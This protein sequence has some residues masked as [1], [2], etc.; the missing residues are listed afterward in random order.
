M[1]EASKWRRLHTCIT[2]IFGLLYNI[3]LLY[4]V[5]FELS[6]CGLGEMVCCIQKIPYNRVPLYFY[7]QKFPTT[8]TNHD[9]YDGPIYWFAHALLTGV[10]ISW[11]V[12]WPAQ[13]V[14][15][16]LHRALCITRSVFHCIL[17]YD[18]RGGQWRCGQREGFWGSWRHAVRWREALWGDLLVR[19]WGGREHWRRVR[20]WTG[21]PLLLAC[22]LRMRV[23]LCHSNKICT[24]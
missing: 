18:H 1:S 8:V 11:L 5:D 13:N 23:T 15:S 17:L 4:Q 14:R 10:H 7:I 6:E 22:V 19:R 16:V 9:C 21:S 12:A 20:L 3:F 2:L 24:K